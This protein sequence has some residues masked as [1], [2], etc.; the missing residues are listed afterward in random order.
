MHEAAIA[1]SVLEIAERE[2]RKHSA[3]SIRKIKLKIGEFTGVVSE[4]LGFAFEALKEQTLANE[5]TLEV[6]L[7]RLKVECP[8]C[9]EGHCGL[10]DFNLLCSKCGGVLTIVAGREMQ[11][12]YI[13][14]G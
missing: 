7:I 5:A 13:D 1:R 10:R 6:E 2:A 3:T 9:L 12:D 4:S 8:K 11:V 14:L